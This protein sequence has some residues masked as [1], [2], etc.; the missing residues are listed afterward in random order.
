MPSAT[1][2]ADDIGARER[3]ERV[4]GDAGE[5]RPRPGRRPAVREQRGRQP[6]VGAEARQRQ[7]VVGHAQHRAQEV[8]GDVVEAVGERPEQG[9]PRLAV[10]AEPG[11]GLLDR[12]PGRGAT[13]AVERVGVLDLRPAPRQPVRAE[14]EA[15][16]ERRVDG[17]RVG[18]RA[19]VVDQAG[20]RQLAAAGAAAERV[21]GLEHR[22]V[23][24][25]G[26]EGEGG[27]EPVG[28][29]A[30]DDGARHATALQRRPR[31]QRGPWL[32]RS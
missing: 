20:Q 7:R 12:A 4:R 29:A 22:H 27:S 6:R 1:P 26:G 30:D 32:T 2:I 11:G 25:L 15:A 24:A 17:E 8:G 28:P 3:P 19:L 14:V 16:R 10:V 9:P 18:G 31:E 21:G 23:D 5:Q 13:P